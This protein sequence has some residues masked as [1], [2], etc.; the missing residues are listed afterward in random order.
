MDI[1]KLNPLDIL[2]KGHIQR[3]RGNLGSNLYS[4]YDKKCTNQIKQKQLDILKKNTYN[5]EEKKVE[6][7]IAA[8]NII[9]KDLQI[10]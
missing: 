10:N 4:N 2:L 3:L 6:F 9:K 5:Y 8:Y 7:T 1:I